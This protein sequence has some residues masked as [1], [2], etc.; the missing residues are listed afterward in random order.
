M[1]EFESTRRGL[2]TPLYP[3]RV[4]ADQPASIASTPSS[5]DLMTPSRSTSDNLPPV[6]V[7]PPSQGRNLPGLTEESFNHILQDVFLLEPDSTLE[8]ALRRQGCK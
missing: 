2:G 4:V 3:Q 5:L 8:Q 7:T 6:S 1:R